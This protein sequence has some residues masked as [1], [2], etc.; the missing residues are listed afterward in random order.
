MAVQVLTITAEMVREHQLLMWISHPSG[1]VTVRCH[2]IV[3]D[4]HPD[5][6]VTK[7]CDVGVWLLRNC[8]G[9]TLPIRAVFDE[10]G[11]FCTWQ[12]TREGWS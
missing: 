10:H 11:L 9:C 4:D 12:A 7:T 2:G 1:N 6:L 3:P 8:G 5:A